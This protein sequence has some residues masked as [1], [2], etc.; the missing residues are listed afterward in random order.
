M[1]NKQT[2]DEGMLTEGTQ[3]YFFG[4][5]LL[6]VVWFLFTI[7]TLG[8][9]FAV[10]MFLAMTL[11]ALSGVMLARAPK[12]NSWVPP[13]VIGIYQGGVVAFMLAI[14]YHSIAPVAWQLL[15]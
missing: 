14:A 9:D 10:P 8:M 7:A 11:A 3:V 6:G 4:G 13:V 15:G 1:T 2:M 12:R 5:V